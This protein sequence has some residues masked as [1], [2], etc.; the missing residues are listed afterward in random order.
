MYIQTKSIFALSTVNTLFLNDWP[1]QA[2]RRL[3]DG[4][5]WIQTQLVVACDRLT[6]GPTRDRRY[7]SPVVV[8]DLRQA[9]SDVRR[10]PPELRR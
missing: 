8:S 10:P 4:D 7:D 2:P 5:N 1:Y 6:L 3:E 9:P